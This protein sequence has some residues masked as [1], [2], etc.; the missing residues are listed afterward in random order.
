MAPFELVMIRGSEG[1]TIL[2][3]CGPDAVL[4]DLTSR[5]AKLGLTFLDATRSAKEIA[6]QLS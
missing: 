5:T 4:S 6:P 3:R 2:V 1:Y